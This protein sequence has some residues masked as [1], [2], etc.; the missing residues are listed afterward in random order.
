[1]TKTM[2]FK[3]EKDLE[4]MADYLVRFSVNFCFC[5]ETSLNVDFTKIQPCYYDS[6]NKAM[7]YYK[8]A[9]KNRRTRR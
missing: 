8:G 7:Y 3:T 1:M 4:K 5:D 9:F 2:Y 6:I